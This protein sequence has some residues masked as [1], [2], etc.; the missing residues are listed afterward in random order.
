MTIN[1][2]LIK[3]IPTSTKDAIVIIQN[4]LVYINDKCAV[5]RQLITLEDLIVYDNTIL[6]SPIPFLYWVYYKP[7][8]IECTMNRNIKNNLADALPLIKD[9]F[10]PIGRLDKESEGLLLLTN[11]GHLYAEIAPDGAFVEKEYIVQVDTVLSNEAIVALSNG[12]IIMG[13]KT[14]ATT[15]TKIDDFTFKIILTQG[16]NRQIRRMCYKLG[17]TVTSLIR[18]RINNVLLENL[19]PGEYKLVNKSFLTIN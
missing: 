4:G 17:Y 15:V 1:D 3:K 12:I 18:I 11:D 2:F 7:R 14:R 9:D 19:K 8:G 6:Q 16:L 10:F 13:K 5:Q